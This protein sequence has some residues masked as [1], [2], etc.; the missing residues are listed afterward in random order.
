MIIGFEINV[1]KLVEIAFHFKIAVNDTR[2][3]TQIITV[4]LVILTSLYEYLNLQLDTMVGMA[5]LS[6][7]CY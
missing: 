3:V 1:S 5:E 2:P 4:Y 6:K 7:L